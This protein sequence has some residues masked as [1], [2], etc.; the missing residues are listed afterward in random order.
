MPVLPVPP[1]VVPAAATPR[2]GQPGPPVISVPPPQPPFRGRAQVLI[3]WGSAPFSTSPSWTDVTPWVRLDKGIS[4]QLRGRQDNLTTVQSAR[5]TLTGDNSD[6]RWTAG[7]STSPWAPGVKIGRRIQVNVPNEGGTLHTR[8]D[9]L[10][11]ELPTAWEGGPGIVSLTAI[12]ASDILAWLGRQPPLLSWTQQEM[13][14]DSPAALWSLTD[15]SNATQATDQ[16]GQGA[17]PLQVVSQ[18]DGTGAA[19]AGSGVP[20]AE[21]GTSNVTAQQQVTT[22]FTFTNQ[23]PFNVTFPPGTLVSCDTKCVAG[24]TAGTNGTFGSNGGASGKGAEFAREPNLVITP[25]K[26]YS[27]SV[28]AGG[29]PSAGAGGD[30]TFTGDSVTV[31]AHGA[32]TGSSNTVHRD[33]GASAA[34]V[35]NNGGGGGSSGGSLQAGNKGVAGGAGGVAVTDGGAGGAGD[36]SGA[37][38]AAGSAPGG[39]GG[40]GHGS[41]TNTSGAAGATGS[42]TIIYT[43]IPA[44]A[45]QQNSSLPSWL[46][47]PSATLAARVLQGQLPQPVTAAAGFAC[48]IRGSFAGFPAAAVTPFTTPGAISFTGPPGVL[49]SDTVATAGGSAGTNGGASAGGAGNN[50]GE[51]AREPSLAITP[52]TVYAG[53]VGAAG[54]PSAGTGGDSFLAG[55]TVTVYAHGSGTGSAN[56]EHHDGGSGAAANGANGG[57]GGSSGGRS[58]AGN[59]GVSIGSTGGVAV[60][61]GGAGG[62]GDTSGAGAAP[63]SA[64]GGGGGGGHG[65]G[66]VSSQAASGAAGQVTVTCQPTVSTLLTL[67]NP[68]GQNAIAV[69]VTS[70]GNLQLA[71]TSGYGTRSPAWTTV[72]AG[73]VPSGAFH[74]AVNVAASTGVATFYVNG[75]SAG[76]LTLPAGAAYTWVTVGAAYGSWL[77]GWNG[78]AGLAAIYPAPLSS[79][80]IG[81]HYTAGATGFAGSSTGTMIARIAAYTGLPSFYY[82]APYGPADPSYG[83]TT[84]SYYDLKGQNPLT[85]MQQYEVAEGGVLYVTAAGR[86]AFADRASRYAAGAAGSAFV[87]SAGQYEPDTSYKSNDQYLCTAACYATVNIPGGYPVVNTTARPDFGYYTANAGTPASPQPAPFADATGTAGSYSTDDLADAGWWQAN[88]FGT[89]VSRVP[90]LTV[91]LLTQPASEFSTAAFYGLDIGSAVQLAG[92]PSQAPDSTGQ[93]NSAYQVI[94]GVNETIGLQA[95]TAQLYT[96]PLSQSTA[97]IPGD[98]LLGVLGSTNTAG[99]SQ[100]PSALGPPYPVPTF[101]PA[102]NRTGSAGAQDW[103]GLTVNV[104]NRLTPPLLI[105]QQASAQTI[106]TLT[107]QAVTFDTLLADTAAG[108]GTTTTYVVPAGFAGYYWCAAVVQAA[109]GT[110]SLGGIAA[111]FAAVLGGVASQWHAKVIPYLSTAPYTSVA[112]AGRIGPCAAGDTIQVIAAAAGSPASLPLGA[113]DGG[114]MFTLFWQGS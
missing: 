104:Q 28:G 60:P 51:E 5:L 98:A 91:D 95:H 68:R 59:G 17:A 65:A 88:V 21:I 34:A 89:P 15:T 10:L 109:T 94:E 30:T 50:G 57:G 13:L 92:L 69:W 49:T 2:W 96:S 25:G 84:V 32:G 114:S 18:G 8:Y 23:G 61:G 56:T 27:G 113:A 81:V 12:Q 105:A 31:T 99:R 40:G 55:D 80:R 108:M 110:A 53:S 102:L 42:C 58:Q 35:G 103:R 44:P 43:Y 20:L 106:T 24:G 82:V 77:G 64:P 9:G 76:T 107:G 19:A 70:A 93:P 66:G 6:G 29:A 78:S 7:R 71:S 46:F 38:A 1:L 11:T 4:L 39:G 67:V 83:L 97:W 86:L 112:I 22:T 63:G 33:G 45:S 111:W 85:A 54:S 62:A 73:Q 41:T 37:G 79:A 101:G 52:D 100:A 75:V 26:T 16:A 74:V 47:T 48:E 90:A 14:A 3:A 36:S 87:L 72:D